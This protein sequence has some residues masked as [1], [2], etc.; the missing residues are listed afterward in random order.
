MSDHTTSEKLWFIY[1]IIL[2]TAT[3][4]FTVL[5]SFFYTDVTPIILILLIIATFPAYGATI[6]SYKKMNTGK[7]DHFNFI[8][9]RDKILP[10]KLIFIGSIIFFPVNFII[11][12]VFLWEGSPSIIEGVYWLTNHGDLVR[13]ISE[14]EYIRLSMA[15]MRLMSGCLLTFIAM[16]VAHFGIRERSKQ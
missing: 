1:S 13:E 2:W 14:A 9:V 8:K 16:P 15:E 6:Y 11:G 3:L 7:N 5:V 12:M 4:S 10:I